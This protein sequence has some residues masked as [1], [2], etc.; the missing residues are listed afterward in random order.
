MTNT[1][2]TVQKTDLSLESFISPPLRHLIQQRDYVLHPIMREIEALGKIL[3]R[4]A[5]MNLQERKCGGIF[6]I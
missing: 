4:L 5:G 6:G 1:E 3:K 2:S